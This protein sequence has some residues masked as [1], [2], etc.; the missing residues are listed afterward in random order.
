MSRLNLVL[1][2]GIPP[3]FHDGAHFGEFSS[4]TLLNIIHRP[5]S[6]EWPV[7]FYLITPII[8]RVERIRNMISSSSVDKCEDDTVLFGWSPSIRSSCQKNIVI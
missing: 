8:V 3:E 5:T 6:S 4:T 7:E 1:T 2:Y